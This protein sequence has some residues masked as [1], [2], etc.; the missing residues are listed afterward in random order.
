MEGFGRW[1]SNKEMDLI[2]F[3]DVFEILKESYT[4]GREFGSG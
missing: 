3:S 4:S 2:H 1:A